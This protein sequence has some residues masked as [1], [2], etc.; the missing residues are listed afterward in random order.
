[1]ITLR[2]AVLPG[3]GIGPEV[4]AEAQKALNVLAAKK[5]FDVEYRMGLVGAASLDKTGEPVTQETLDM[6]RECDSILFGAIGDPRWDNAPA[7]QRPERGLLRIRKEFGC[8][9]NLRPIKVFPALKSMSVLRPDILEKGVDIL[10]FRE[11]TGGV[12]YREPKGRT[13]VDGQPAAVDTMLYTEG[14]IERIARVAFVAAQQRRKKVTSVDKANVLASSQLWREVVT[15]VAADYPDVTLEHQL[16][17]SMAMK[18]I[19]SPSNYDV[20]LTENMFGDILSDEGGVLTGSLGMLPSGTISLAPPSFFEPVHGSAPD[21]AG[22][23][24]A[25]PLGMILSL[26][27]MLRYAFQMEAEAQEIEAV[28]ENVLNQGYRTADIAHA[29]EA[30]V[31]VKLVSTQQ[32]GDLIAAQLG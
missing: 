9:A 22:Q 10:M 7:H 25:N 24:K 28:V 23:G 1:V 27:M 26:A 17:D 32:M 13:T 20:I 19:T 16:V 6:C 12:Y 2:I 21:I 14:E 15:K 3:D 5:G 18:L 4:M 8:F 30:G 31:E 11:L 29:R